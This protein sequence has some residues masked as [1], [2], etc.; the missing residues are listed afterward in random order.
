MRRIYKIIIRETKYI[1]SNKLLIFAL[2]AFPVA[3]FLFLGG[4]YISQELNKMPVAVIDNDNSKISKNIIR[5]INSSP[6]MEIK[7]RVANTAELKDL[8]DRQKVFMG[9][10]IPRELQKNIKKQ[11]PQKVIIFINSSNYISANLI[12]ADITTIIAVVSAGIKYKTLTKRGFSSKQS[13]ELIQQIK[14][15][16][17]KLFNPALN[18]NLYLTPGLWLSVIQ[19][20]LILFGGLTLA[21]EFDFK[22]LRS[23]LAVTRKSIFKALIGKTLFYIFIGCIH[24]FILY[25]ILFKIFQIP[26]AYSAGAAMLVSAVFAFA[27]ISLGLLLAAILKTRFNTLKGCLLI[28]AP[29]FLLSGYTW[30]LE[31]MPAPIRT[32]VQIIPLTSFLKAFKKIYQENL[33]IEFFYPYVLQLLILG[34]LFFAAAWAIVN[35]RINK[36]GILNEL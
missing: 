29:A 34:V 31:L 26:I 3:D 27:A 33:G 13:R 11:K 32:F 2:L 28:S 5:Y 30:P 19:Q 18:Y 9:I 22:T 17:A 35:F 24:F 7:Y 20:L 4:V 15:E 16:T 21:S 23:M 14:P 25:E 6:E 12:D 1:F 8:F 10:Y 36:T